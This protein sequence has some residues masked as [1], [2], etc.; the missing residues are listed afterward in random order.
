MKGPRPLEMCIKCAYRGSRPWTA[1]GRTVAIAASL[2]AFSELLLP[3]RPPGLGFCRQERTGP[4]F[5]TNTGK[6][7]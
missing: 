4:H 6:R 1:D 3:I 2:I 7:E 5:K